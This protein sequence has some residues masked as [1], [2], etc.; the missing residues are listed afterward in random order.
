MAKTTRDITKQPKPRVKGT[1][2]PVMVRLQPELAAPLDAWLRKQ[3][4]RPTRAEAIR[5]LVVLGLKG[6]AR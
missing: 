6:K 2:E 4:D 1:G 5:R 3:P